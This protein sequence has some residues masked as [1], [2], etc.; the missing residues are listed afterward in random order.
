MMQIAPPTPPLFACESD[1]IYADPNAISD[2]HL[3]ASV[4][5]NGDFNHD[6]F[7]D[8]LVGGITKP[9]PDEPSTTRALL[10]L[11]T[12]SGP[13]TSPTFTFQGNGTR[14]QFGVRVSF[15]PDLN[16]DTFEEAM[17]SAPNWPNQDTKVGQVYIFLGRAVTTSTPHELIVADACADLRIQGELH[18]GR[19]GDSMTATSFLDADGATD[20]I[21][22]APGSDLTDGT[23]YAGRMH[24]FRGN[25]LAGSVFASAALNVP[26]TQSSAPVAIRASDADLFIDG[27]N[28]ADR[29]G[30]SVAVIGNLDSTPGVEFCVG[31]PQ[32][33]MDSSAPR[34]AT[35][36]GYVRFVTHDGTSPF[37]DLSGS[38]G[39]ITDPNNAGLL[40]SDGEGFGFSVA[41]GTDLAGDPFGDPD[42]TNDIL[43]GAI[44]YDADF[45][46]VTASARRNA[47]A[48]HVFSGADRSPLLIDGSGTT[49]LQGELI[50]NF[51]GSDVAFVPDMV[52]PG[53]VLDQRPDILVGA[54]HFGDGGG[55]PYAACNG[56]SQ[57]GEQ[58]GALYVMQGINGT[59][60]YRIAGEASK[61]SLGHS[62]AGR[63]LDMNGTVDILSGSLGWSGSTLPTETGRIYLFLNLSP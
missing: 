9:A 39:V 8:L 56:Q 34:G 16:G 28:D 12:P 45:T 35:G 42:G 48:V 31:A 38:Q 2:E 5:V 30:L 60:R 13:S 43:I 33:K 22:G 50:D 37:P 32:L 15:I 58:A 40:I 19:F 49:L 29:F 6:G 26:C 1:V 14:D 54:Y 51:F 7:P 59:L 46:G 36:P 63:D 23:G 44:L 41:G 55:A 17:V 11:G 57:G 62:V 3:G 21:I 20:L 24:V 47:G 52:G 27:D 18:G 10:F 4:A 25:G 53:L 61:D